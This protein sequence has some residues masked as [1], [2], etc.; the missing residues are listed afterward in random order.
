MLFA[1]LQRT[2]QQLEALLRARQQAAAA[3]PAAGQQA[4]VAQETP[5]AGHEHSAAKQ[6]ALAATWEAQTAK[7]RNTPKQ[8]PLAEAAT[9]EAAIAQLL[10]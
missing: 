1:Q 5:T 6:A 7:R 9:S 10:A 2:V 8:R 3:T 4:A